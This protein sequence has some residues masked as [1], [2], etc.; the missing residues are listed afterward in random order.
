[1][2]TAQEARILRRIKQLLMPDSVLEM[3][4]VE[5]SPA[6]WMAVAVMNSGPDRRFRFQNGQLLDE[7]SIGDDRV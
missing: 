4:I 2:Q 7:A 1:M 3:A 5:A 6:S